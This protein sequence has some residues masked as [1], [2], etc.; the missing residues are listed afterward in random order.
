MLQLVQQ[1][2]LRRWSEVAKH[3]RG[4][5]GKQCRERWVVATFSICVIN[6][7]TGGLIISTLTLNGLP[8]LRKKI[9]ESF[10]HIRNSAIGGQKS[11]KD[12]LEGTRFFKSC[13]LVF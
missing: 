1:Y 7:P 10:K 6:L 11:P 9:C 5:L 4:R 12:Y 3:L 2:G 8:G 13:G